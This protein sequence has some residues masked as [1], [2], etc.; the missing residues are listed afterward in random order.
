MIRACFVGRQRKGSIEIRG[1]QVASWSSHWECRNETPP[2]PSR[3]DVVV[4]VKKPPGDLLDAC[5][6][7]G[8][9]CVL[10][11]VDGW[12]QPVLDPAEAV[13]TLRRTIAEYD[14]VIYP[15]A[16]F[17]AD[18]PHP[19]GHVIYHH[20]RPTAS[21]AP[22]R[23]RV[24]TVGYEGGERY[25]GRWLPVLRRHSEAVGARFVVNPRDYRSLDV[26]VAVRAPPYDDP[27]S[28]RY[29]S[30]VKMANAI[31]HGVPFLFMPEPAA[32]ETCPVPLIDGGFFA[33][34]RTFLDLLRAMLPQ[35][36]RTD[37]AAQLTRARP[38]FS[39]SAIFARYEEVFRAVLDHYEVGRPDEVADRRIADRPPPPRP[40]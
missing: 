2:D 3:Y 5:R 27:L 25:L 26:V 37:I 6:R 15:C 18:F 34:S 8:V 19:C 28:T 31:G 16:A 9:P 14:A 22:I 4:A 40:A 11:V 32:L 13:R 12:R 39:P 21:Q 24:E 10:D 30:N 29:K 1:R 33:D 17:A 35:H 38:L 7:A 36:V 23:P 20:W